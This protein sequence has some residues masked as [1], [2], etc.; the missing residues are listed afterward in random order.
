MGLDAACGA[1][2]GGERGKRRFSRVHKLS[3]GGMEAQQ[4]SSV[5]GLDQHVCGVSVRILEAVCANHQASQHPRWQG[6]GR[7]G[8]KK[9]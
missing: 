5:Q 4:G 6:E 7:V 9:G 3:L 1:A 2:G 8:E